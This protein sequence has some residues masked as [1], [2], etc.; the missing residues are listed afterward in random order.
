GRVGRRAGVRYEVRRIS[1]PSAGACVRGEASRAGRGRI[2]NPSYLRRHAGRHFFS[3]L[4]M[5]SVIALASSAGVTLVFLYA[6]L[7]SLPMMNVHRAAVT[8]G[9]IS[10]GLPS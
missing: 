9:V 5:N 6:T 2:G 1:N 8:P 3:A 7:P 4:V 10:I